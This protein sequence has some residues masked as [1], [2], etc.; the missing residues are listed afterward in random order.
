M[1]HRDNLAYIDPLSASSPLADRRDATFTVAAGLASSGCYSFQA[2]N[3]P[4]Y[5]LRHYDMRL[6][7]QRERRHSDLQG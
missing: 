4:G 7:L 5:Y 3:L 1:R 2:V 6:V